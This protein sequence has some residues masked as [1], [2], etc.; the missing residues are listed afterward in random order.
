MATWTSIGLPAPLEESPHRIIEWG[1]LEGTLK[2]NHSNPCLRLAALHQLRLPMSHPTWLQAPPGWATHSN[3]GILCQQKKNNNNPIQQNPTPQINGLLSSIY[4][5]KGAARFRTVLSIQQSWDINWF[6]QSACETA[7]LTKSCNLQQ[8]IAASCDSIWY[9]LSFHKE[10]PMY[11]QADLPSPFP[12]STSSH[13]LTS[14]PSQDF[15]GSLGFTNFRVSPFLDYFMSRTPHKWQQSFYWLH[16]KAAVPPPHLHLS[17]KVTAPRW[18]VWDPIRTGAQPL[19]VWQAICMGNVLAIGLTAIACT[20]EQM[21][22]ERAASRILCKY[23]LLQ[24]R[25][26]QLT[27]C[28]GLLISQRK[29]TLC[30]HVASAGG[31][32][33]WG[34]GVGDAAFFGLGTF[35]TFAKR[36]SFPAWITLTFFLNH[37]KTNKPV[38][39]PK[40]NQVMAT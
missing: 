2:P 22:G 19:G 15:M 36:A 37:T 17:A 35:L 34:W 4:Q 24:R 11:A 27:K 16:P 12:I 9:E 28:R 31:C 21:T 10:N 18:Q 40:P 25:R 26:H 20:N 1:R 7:N 38:N 14:A 33:V 6:W 32:K 5:G 29:Q 39:S 13:L 3:L 23:R 30:S 8:L